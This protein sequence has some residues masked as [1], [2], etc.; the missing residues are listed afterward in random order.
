MAKI[1]PIIATK[2]K[3]N[4]KTGIIEYTG[5]THDGVGLLMMPEDSETSK[6]YI[7][8]PLH[9]GGEVVVKMSPITLPVKKF[10]I[11]DVVAELI[12]LD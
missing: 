12:T 10:S 9:K 5:Q 3:I 6:L 4:I 2:E 8:Q 11:G 7:V 1:I